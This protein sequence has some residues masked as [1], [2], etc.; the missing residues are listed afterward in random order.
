MLA[1]VYPA[2]LGSTCP[3]RAPSPPSP[4]P[5]PSPRA[6]NS[7]PKGREGGVRG[8]RAGERAAAKKLPP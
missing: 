3:P 1:A 2:P 5:L 7:N 6:G 8:W 4:G